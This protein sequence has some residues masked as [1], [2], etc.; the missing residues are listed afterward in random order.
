MD[1]SKENQIIMRKLLTLLFI[2]NCLLGNAQYDS[3]KKRKNTEKIS[4][5]MLAIGGGLV[6]I[7]AGS[8]SMKT[9]GETPFVDNKT[10]WRMSPSEWAIVGG[11]TVVTFGIIYKF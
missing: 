11:F 5:R 6:F 9:K 1:I 4:T 2:C 10:I 7:T 8:I 3:K